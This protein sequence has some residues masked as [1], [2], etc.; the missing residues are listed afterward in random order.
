MKDVNVLMLALVLQ[1]FRFTING[2]HYHFTTGAEVLITFLPERDFSISLLSGQ[3][4]L[5]I[6]S[7]EFFIGINIFT[8]LNILYLAVFKKNV[9]TVESSQLEQT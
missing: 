5:A 8:F 9:L 7:K 2:F 6:N 4:G 1:I 3:F